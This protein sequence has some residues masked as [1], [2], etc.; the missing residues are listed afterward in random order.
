MRAVFL[1]YASQDAEAARR[2]CDSLRAGGVEVWFDA[3]GGLEHGDEWDAKIRRQIKE[4]V[5]FIPVISANTQARHEGYFR[6]E[7]DL[8]AERARGIASG[9]PFI[10]PVVI[11]DTAEPA[12]LVPD[13]FRAVQWTRLPG[14]AVPSEVLTRFLKLWSDRTGAKQTAVVASPAPAT[15]AH[16]PLAS[17]TPS[18]DDKSIAVLPFANMSADA[19]N[20]YFSDGMTEEIINALV[21]VPDLRVAA[22]TSVFAFKGKAD[23]LRTIAGKLNVRTVLEGSVRKAGNRIRITAQLINAAD[24]FHLWSEKFD[25]GLEDIFAV[26]DEI[27]RTIAE[28]LKAKLGGGAR[29]S[30]VQAPTSDLEAYQLYL[31]GRFYWHQRGAGLAKSLKYYE[32]ALLRDPNFALVHAG[33]ADTYLLMGFFGH[34]RPREIIPKARAAV[35]RA[36][37][38]EPEMAEA[39]C[40]LGYILTLFERDLR[41]GRSAYERAIARKPTYTP[42]YSW[43]S[44]I[45]S[46]LGRNDAAV[47]LNLRALRIDPDSLQAGV[48]FG[49]TKI[50]AGR[51]EE[52]I[53]A[54]RHVLEVEPRFFPGHW[55]LGQALIG[56]GRIAEGLEALRRAVECSQGLPW[57]VATLGCGLVCAGQIAEARALLDEL[58]RRAEREYVAAFPIA[59]LQ[60]YLGEEEAAHASLEQAIVDGDPAFVWISIDVGPI[61]PMAI[62]AA[63]LSAPKRAAF[64]ERLGL[65]RA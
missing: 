22:R 56:T 8:A 63:Y 57:M 39:L 65:N 14:G 20:E 35:D 21:Q 3:D 47:G 4:C 51:P 33:I 1:S 12:A 61:S 2:I 43:Y 54:E 19:E 48:T 53:A 44:A 16:H 10:L 45:E 23:D 41:A 27:A 17:L 18:P 28:K 52:A 13:R 36:L 7:W 46:A 29:Q 9:V 5:L 40:A 49:W 25:R 24:G 32:S 59:M 58:T 6:I 30:L 31:K 11:D 26:Q 37:A 64:V 34:A 15:A 50:Y 55:I 42:S 38:L 62:P 60:S